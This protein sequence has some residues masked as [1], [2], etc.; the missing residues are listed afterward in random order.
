[1]DNT[2][3][4]RISVNPHQTLLDKLIEK[5]AAYPMSGS[6]GEII[7]PRAQYANFINGL[8][9]LG[10]AVKE[11][12]WWCHATEDYKKR[13]GCPHGMGG[14]QTPVGWFTELTPDDDSLENEILKAELK[15]N[16]SPTSIKAIN[17]K[18]KHLITYKQTIT[19]AHGRPMTFRDNPCLTPGIG[20]YMAGGWEREK[21]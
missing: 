21:R 7:V 10:L 12:S 1:M 13:W 16:L 20:I 17:E 15:D 14:P 3:N 5:H 18:A 2:N 6:Y 4:P 19:T 8:T 11:I 9:Q